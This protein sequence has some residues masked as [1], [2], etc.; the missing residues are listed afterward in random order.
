M[1]KNNN[2]IIDKANYLN[3][4][5]ILSYGALINMVVGDRGCGK[6]YGAKLWC[7]K[8]FLKKGEKF[9]YIK[10]YKSDLK[11]NDKF[12]ADIGLDPEISVHEFKVN[13]SK[14]YIDKQLCGE[15]FSLSMAQSKKSTS[16]AEYNNMIFDE[17]ILEPGL[18]RYLE[19]EVWKF[20]SLIDTVVRNRS[21]C[22]VFVLGNSVR[23]ANPYFTFYKF[24]PGQSGIQIKQ[25]GTILLA[26]YISK[27]FR[28][29][30]QETE[31]GKLIQGTEYA[32][33]AMFS[34]YSDAN[35]DFIK[36]KS[37]KAYLVATM[38]WQGK[39]YGLWFDEDC[40]I[41]SNKCNKE[42]MV[43][44]YTKDDFK[45]NMFLIT[46]KTLRINMT[47]KKA[48]KYSYLYYEDIYIRDAIFD[49]IGA[50]GIR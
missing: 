39:Y 1:K 28:E 46:D 38:Y 2:V 22:K 34:E 17:F 15:A 33:M 30:R 7:V 26:N 10:R 43:L 14:F 21:G 41:F 18:T 37:K 36:K 25:D 12:F 23:W 29:Q 4:D 20:L 48:F 32:R 47:I 6:S 40:Y 50:M 16:Y 11:D 9:L 45:P 35:D 31:V 19:N 44:C 13:G 49:L 27:E 24:T 3:Y 8:R 5:K 42:T